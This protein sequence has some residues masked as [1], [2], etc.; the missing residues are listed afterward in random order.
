MKRP[1]GS[2]FLSAADTR[3]CPLCLPRWVLVLEQRI[4]PLVAGG[5]VPR[6]L[7][8]L[9]ELLKYHLHH[10]IGC[11]V[12]AGVVCWCSVLVLA[13]WLEQKLHA[14]LY[15]AQTY[16]VLQYYFNLILFWFFWLKAFVYF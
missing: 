10:L 13:P 14:A 3:R 8:E 2:S 15:A 4:L 6:Q 11:C 9:L 16:A 1:E 7:L 5:I 12:C